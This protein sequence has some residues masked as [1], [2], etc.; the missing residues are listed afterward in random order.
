M[1]IDKKHIL[2]TG[3]LGFIG[4]NLIIRLLAGDERNHLIIVDNLQCNQ[5]LDLIKAQGILDHPRVRIYYHNI[6]DHFLYSN[7]LHDY[8]PYDHPISEIYHLASIASPIWYKKF[9][10]ETLDV[11]YTGTKN[12]L[13]FARN[14][15]GVRVLL[16]SSSEVYGDAEV[17]P[18]QESYFGNT[19]SYG[20]RSCYDEGKRVMEA[21][22]HSY[23]RVYGADGDLKIRIARIFNTYGP[24]MNIE[25]GRVIPSFIKSILSGKP[26][27]MFNGGM[28]TRCFNYI[29]DT[30]GGLMSL[31]KSDL[32]Q[33]VNIGNDREITMWELLE[34]MKG[35]FR[36][37]FPEFRDRIEQ[38]EIVTGTSDRDDPKVRR[39]HL[40][41][42]SQYLGYE[43]KNCLEKGLEET[44]R[45][46]ILASKLGRE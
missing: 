27:K 24:Y 34:I 4:T 35:V 29:D 44:I 2:I 3:G 16:A 33:P 1:E 21:M 26:I 32:D 19:N 10:I 7:I 46:F 12:V 14:Y 38:M 15:P 5:S 36:E 18:Q 6:C 41:L 22:A 23:Q 43:I 8:S 40:G 17:S 11:S 39:P 28:Q 45:Y 42:A 20:D 37:K 31:M 13:E 25:D 9:P 30:M